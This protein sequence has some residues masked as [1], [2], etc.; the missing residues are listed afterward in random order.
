MRPI[1]ITR[2]APVAQ[3]SLERAV[4]MGLDA[5]IASLFI[6]SPMP[7]IAPDPADYDALF[8]SSAQS[9]RLGGAGLDRLK[10]LPVYAVGPATG[11]A[12]AS[13]GFRVVRSGDSDGQTLIAEMEG[14]GIR[15]ILWLC[16]A[17]HSPLSGDSARL[18]ILPCYQMDD[19]A[20]PPIWNQMIQAP[21]VVTAYSTRASQRIAALIGDARGHIALLAISEKV[22][23]A[24]GSGW[25]QVVI[26]A[27]PDDAGM[28]AAAALLCHNNPL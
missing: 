5:H 15:S 20:P 19:L 27:Q 26:A 17:R 25:G 1:L 12:A 4:S 24:A 8:I 28:L 9:L 21:V 22:A 11:Q 23:R 2:P 14:A 10:N 6:A 18:D 3:A 16:G 13:A 7:W